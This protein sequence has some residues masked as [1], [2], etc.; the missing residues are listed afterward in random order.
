[1]D[2]VL[3][4]AFVGCKN[5]HG[6]GNLKFHFLVDIFSLRSHSVENSLWKSLWTCSRRDCVMMTKVMIVTRFTD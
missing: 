1:M 3:L 5:M 4:G 2:C 6:I